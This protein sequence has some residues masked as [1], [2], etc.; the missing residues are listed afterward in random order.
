MQLLVPGSYPFPNRPP[1]VSAVLV[2]RELVVDLLREAA[3]SLLE[4]MPSGY[5]EICSA[6]RMYLVTDQGVAREADQPAH[7]WGSLWNV[8]VY[9]ILK[10]TSE[11]TELR[12]KCPNCS[13]GLAVGF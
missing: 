1:F 10:L 11:S 4:S 2:R 13:L 6:V 8:A 7:K 9:S 3:C 12:L 5:L